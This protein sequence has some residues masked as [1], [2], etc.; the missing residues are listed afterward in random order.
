MLA[1]RLGDEMWE[2][3]Q[4]GTEAL[5]EKWL[6]KEGD[7]VSAG[8]P[9]ANVVLVKAA[10]EVSAP[11]SGRIASILVAAEQTFGPGRDLALL[12]PAG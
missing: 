2:G 6:V 4:T 1:I 8:Q 11:A 7:T 9:V 3:V 5:L 10:I 12:E